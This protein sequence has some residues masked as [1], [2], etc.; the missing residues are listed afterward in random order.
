MT[1]TYIAKGNSKITLINVFAVKAEQQDELVAVLNEA[2]HAHLY[3][4][5]RCLGIAQGIKF[6]V[7]VPPIL[8]ER[9]G[10]CPW[11]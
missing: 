11:E 8:P 6:S 7:S 5:R 4:V 3:E 1:E 10:T 2:T 9:H